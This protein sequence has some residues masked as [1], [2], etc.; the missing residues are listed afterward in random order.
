M[1]LVPLL[2]LDDN[3]P[4]LQPNMLIKNHNTSFLQHPKQRLPYPLLKQLVKDG[5]CERH[6]HALV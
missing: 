5:S 4:D 2:F 6:E 3:D 1:F